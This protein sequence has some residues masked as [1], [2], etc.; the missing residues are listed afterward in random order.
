MPY[1]YNYRWMEKPKSNIII[2]NLFNC[3]AKLKETKLRQ[4][5]K[6]CLKIVQNGAHF[7]CKGRE[8][9]F[10]WQKRKSESAPPL[11]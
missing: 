7:D 6:L 10:S 3:F 11:S 4:S 2:D 9:T 5:Q 8:T 1:L